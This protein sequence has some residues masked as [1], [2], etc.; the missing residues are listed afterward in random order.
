MLGFLFV[1]PEVSL[2]NAARLAGRAA[3]FLC[4]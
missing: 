2:Y 1:F 4:F 3:I